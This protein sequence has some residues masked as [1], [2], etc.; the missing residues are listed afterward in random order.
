MLMDRAT[1]SSGVAWVFLCLGR[2]ITMAAPKRN[3]ELY[4]NR[5]CLLNL[6]L[7]GSII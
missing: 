7:F 2:V 1:M 5:D 3:Y 4:M 6:V